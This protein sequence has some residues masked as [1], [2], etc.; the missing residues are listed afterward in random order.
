MEVGAWNEDNERSRTEEVVGQTKVKHVHAG[1]AK[2]RG[3]GADDSALATLSRALQHN[4]D[5]LFQRE[6]AP[7]Q[8][9]AL[10]RC[11]K[12]CIRLTSPRKRRSLSF[13]PLALLVSPER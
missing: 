4:A 11:R 8:P 3:D 12:Q 5:G 10:G 9:A 6:R 2:L 13:Q 7:Q 1:K